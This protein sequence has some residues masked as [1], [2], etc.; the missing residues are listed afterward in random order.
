MASEA[1][2]NTE[3]LESDED[4]EPI[5]AQKVKYANYPHVELNIQ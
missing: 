1:E 3:G 2:L 4:E 5:T